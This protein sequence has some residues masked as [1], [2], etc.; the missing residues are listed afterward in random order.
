MNWR[1]KTTV[2]IILF[3]S[4]SAYSGWVYTFGT[5][6]N[7]NLNF[8]EKELMGKQIWQTNNCIACH[9]LYGLGGYLGPDLTRI[10]SDKQRGKEYAAAFLR[11]GGVTMP[12]FH[13]TEDQIN[14]VL[15]YLTYVDASVNNNQIPAP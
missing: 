13:L 3:L 11:S 6:D 14:A 2:F 4:Y 15:A 10:I 5:E 7:K 9:Q 12:N 8:G 1:K